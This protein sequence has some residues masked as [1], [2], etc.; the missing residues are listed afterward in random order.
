MLKTVQGTKGMGDEENLKPGCVSE[1]IQQEGLEFL[2][3]Q[4]ALERW[5][6]VLPWDNGIQS[7]LGL[8]VILAS[9]QQ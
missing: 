3:I 8:L 9:C 7:V 4:R 5:V 2:F 1:Q 6:N